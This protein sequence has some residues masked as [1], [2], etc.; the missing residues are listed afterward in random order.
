M[1]FVLSVLSPAEWRVFVVGVFASLVVEL[2]RI[3][4]FWQTNHR[5]PND[6]Y[7]PPYYVIRLALALA[8]GGLPLVYGV[9]SSVLAL[10]LG[11]SAPLIFEQI[12]NAPP[13]L[14]GGS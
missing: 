11:A 8:A 9:E 2:V 1:F 3:W 13:A 7:K 5:L 4:R 12:A 10:H 14:P 6:C